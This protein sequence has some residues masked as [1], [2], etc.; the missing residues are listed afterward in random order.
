MDVRLVFVAEG[1]APKLKADTMSKRNEIRRGGSRKP[2]NCTVRTGRSHFKSVLRECCELLDYLGN[3]WVCAAGEAEA[4]CAYLNENGY[5][6]GCITNDGDT[7]LYGAQTVYRNLTI[8]TKDPHVD[9]YEMSAIKSKLGLDRDAL[10]GFAIL[11]G[12]DYL[13]KGVP[14]VGKE[15]ALKLVE[16]M[17]GQSLLQRFKLWKRE[18]D[19]VGTRD[20][21]VKK[22]VHCS[23][24]QHPGS[25]REHATKGCQLCASGQSCLLHSSDYQCSCDWHRAEEKRKTNSLED[26]IKKKAKACEHFPFKEVIREFLISKDQPIQKPQWRRPK[27]LLL[28]NFAL[29]KMEWPRHYTCEKVLPLLSHYDM[30][31]RRLGKRDPCHLQPVSIVKTR[32]RNGTPCFEIQWEK[33]EHYVYPSEQSEDSQGTVTTIEER[34]LFETT[35]PDITAQF[36]EGKAEEKEK[37]HQ[38]SK[39]KKK[40]KTTT[41]P[42]EITHLMS[43]MSLQPF[44]KGLTAKMEPGPKNTGQETNASNCT[45][46]SSSAGFSTE[47]SVLPK[48]FWRESTNEISQPANNQSAEEE[49]SD[50]ES[51]FL[52]AS[53][54]RMSPCTVSPSV[55]LLVAELHLSD[56]DWSQSF[57]TSLSECTP[58]IQPETSEQAQLQISENCC[59]PISSSIKL[60]EDEALKENTAVPSQ[61]CVRKNMKLFYEDTSML[62]DFDQLPLKDRILLKNSRQFLSLPQPNSKSSGNNS[63]LCSASVKGDLP[64]A[65]ANTESLIEEKLSKNS[66]Q[67][68]LTRSLSSENQHPQQVGRKMCTSHKT[69]GH[70]TRPS[71]VPEKKNVKD[72]V[73]KIVG[74][75]D[76]TMYSYQISKPNSISFIEEKNKAS[77]PPK[78]KLVSG[79]GSTI[80]TSVCCNTYLSSEDSDTENSRNRKQ[81]RGIKLRAGE[82]T[83]I[84]FCTSKLGQPR[85]QQNKSRPITG[86]TC[87]TN[88]QSQVVSVTVLGKNAQAQLMSKHSKDKSKIDVFQKNTSETNTLSGNSTILLKS[89]LR[90]VENYKNFS[91]DEDSIIVI[92][93]SPLPLSERLN[94]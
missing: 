24:C 35:Y 57:S 17:N 36:H 88:N 23:V 46:I 94:L 29:D 63:L 11:L 31:E 15:Q 74:I 6:D 87:S 72:S 42:D 92:S 3:P 53:E 48:E 41:V 58:I 32:V 44:H 13:P 90:G 49:K 25:A 89:P 30:M 59:V 20:S 19:E 18:F 73:E 5:V 45:H 28:Q 38:K 16:T 62:E 51:L 27:L 34:L 2:G 86:I 66:N 91:G 67:E 82:N 7:F 75:H 85:V 65:E 8:N 22:K 56:I 4:M 83:M 78:M 26:I 47:Y 81:K 52:K 70:R 37:K 33:P 80:A 71:T 10:I 1:V 40:D 76:P 79:S 39:S 84:P 14:G 12:C 21:L 61:E 64:S 69:A 93:D 55:S 77:K 54:N 43:G 68:K 50:S 60:I 9:C